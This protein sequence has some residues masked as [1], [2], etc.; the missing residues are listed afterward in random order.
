MPIT[1]LLNHLEPAPNHSD[2]KS[3]GGF[4]LQAMECAGVDGESLPSALRGS[5]HSLRSGTQTP[6]KPWRGSGAEIAH[7]II[8]QSFRKK[9]L[10]LQNR[11]TC[12]KPQWADKAEEQLS[13]RKHSQIPQAA[14]RDTFNYIYRNPLYPSAPPSLEVTT[15]WEGHWSL[16]VKWKSQESLKPVSLHFIVHVTIRFDPAVKSFDRLRKDFQVN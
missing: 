14:G 4:G 12:H 5:F 15:K 2:R 6:A 16:P 3:F 13:L 1:F 9:L 8:T 7:D 10:G 11:T